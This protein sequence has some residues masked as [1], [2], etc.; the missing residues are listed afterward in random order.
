MRAWVEQ[1]HSTIEA[2][3]KSLIKSK[4]TAS[5]LNDINNQLEYCNIYSANFFCCCYLFVKFVA[6]D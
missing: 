5:A 1:T 3:T 4:R 2:Y 6:L